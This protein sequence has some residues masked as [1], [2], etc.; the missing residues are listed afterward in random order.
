MFTIYVFKTILYY[1]IGI[2]VNIQTE[3]Y[4]ILYT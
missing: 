4:G 1:A 3:V 2:I